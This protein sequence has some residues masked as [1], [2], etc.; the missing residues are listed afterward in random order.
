VA[1][2]RNVQ[3]EVD[4]RHAVIDVEAAEVTEGK[5]RRRLIELFVTG[6]TR[7]FL[8]ANG[9]ES[10]S[11]PVANL[12]SRMAIDATDALVSGGEALL[13]LLRKA[14]SHVADM[15]L[16]AKLQVPVSQVSEVFRNLVAPNRKPEMA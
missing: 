12:L 2:V 7:W 8:K 6:L 1:P 16:D 10:I 5:G 9:L 3:T 4:P 11:T 14:P 13:R 15:K